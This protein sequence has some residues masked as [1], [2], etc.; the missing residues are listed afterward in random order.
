M[1]GFP[2]TGG[3][4]VNGDGEAQDYE[5]WANTEFGPQIQA[6]AWSEGK[7]PPEPVNY[8]THHLW[9][10]VGGLIAVILV[11]AGVVINAVIATASEKD[12]LNSWPSGYVNP[13][14]QGLASPTPDPPPPPAGP[15]V[16]NMN[17][18]GHLT[19]DGDYLQRM[20]QAGLTWNDAGRDGIIQSAHYICIDVG[21][22]FTP[23]HEAQVAYRM[24]PASHE[25]T[26]DGA[27]N[28]VHIAV[29]VY[30]PGLG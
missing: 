30:C 17:T 23:E 9:W 11:L 12:G 24:A 15:F 28:W 18:A 4:A 29:A 20:S 8:R 3:L 16:P 5:E 27:R 1:S 26:L 13:P 25:L 10:C 14:S 2:P 21:N 22:G 6:Q 7:R 19:Q